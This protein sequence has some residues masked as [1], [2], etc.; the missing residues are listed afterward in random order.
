MQIPLLSGIYTTSQYRTKYPKNLLPVSLDSGISKGF[1][2]TMKGF[3]I[4]ANTYDLD[5]SSNPYGGRDRGGIWWNNQH[6]RVIGARLVEVSSSGTLTDI[7]SVGG[8]K[9]DAKCNF[10]Y[11][12]DYL[13]IR[14]GINLYLYDG[15]TLTQ[16][17]DTDLGD[18][19][20]FVW[21]DGYFMTTD[22]E[23]LIITDLTDPFSINPIKYGTSEIDPDPVLGLLRINGEVYVLNRNTIEVFDNQ[24]SEGFPFVRIEGAMINKGVIGTQAKCLALG[25]FFFVG[26]S[27]NEELGVYVAGSGNAD[28]ISTSEIDMI[29][30]SYPL[31]YQELIEMEYRNTD[32]QDLIYIHLPDKTLCYN[33]TASISVKQP[34]WFVLSH[35]SDEAYRP[36]NFVYAYGEW[37]CGDTDIFTQEGV[38]DCS[39]LGTETDTPNI[40][41]ERC[42]WEFTTS[43]LYNEARGALLN[44]L[45]LIS[46]PGSAVI[47]REP[48]VFHSWS[49]DGKQ[50]SNE[51][52]CSMGAIGQYDQRVFW[53]RGGRMKNFR[54][55]RFRAMNGQRFS[56]ARLEAD[57][58]AL[59][60]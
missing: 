49:D 52:A 27:R 4:A 35:G 43:F 22:G 17:T 15:T 36:R 42:E 56:V 58:E 5:V 11:S 9:T 12:T 32:G 41:G 19:V 60:A 40:F 48:T 44:K 59:N 13:A 51:R 57:V 46:L 10:D 24:L 29:I 39:Y 54:S 8:S 18:V 25:T 2:R 23:F 30:N 20:D 55:L 26:S 28:K 6:I 1:L 21:I 7:G 47:D 33:A 37:W 53:R 16:I 31:E 38:D 14:S 45:E 3:G 34:V 50:W